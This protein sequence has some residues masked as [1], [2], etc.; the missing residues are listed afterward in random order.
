MSRLFFLRKPANR[1]SMAPV[2]PAQFSFPGCARVIVTSSESE[3]AG[4]AAGTAMTM[5]ALEIRAIGRKS[6][7]LYG[8]LGRLY[9]WAVIDET[10]VANR[11]WSSLA[12]VNVLMAM[13]PS[14]P[15]R[16]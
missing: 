8:T 5:T 2:V 14:P 1:K 10:G 11:T 13:I 6:S 7:Q 3:L 16:V 9:G 4:N 12:E 15:G